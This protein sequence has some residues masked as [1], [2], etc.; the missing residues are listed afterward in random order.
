MLLLEHVPAALRREAVDY[1]EKH[2]GQQSIFGCR[3]I[4]SMNFCVVHGIEDGTCNMRR[5]VYLN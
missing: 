2:A 3:H 5:F 4:S 1:P